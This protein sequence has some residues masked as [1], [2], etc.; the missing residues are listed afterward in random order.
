VEVAQRGSRSPPHR[1]GAPEVRLALRLFLEPREEGQGQVYAVRRRPAGTAGLCDHRP[2]GEQ[3]GLPPPG[4]PIPG[5][6]TGPARAQHHHRRGGRGAPRHIRLRQRLLHEDR[7]AHRGE[8]VLRGPGRPHN[9]HDDPQ[10]GRADQRLS[11]E[12][13]PRR[14]G[15]GV[16]LELRLH[17]ACQEGPDGTLR[18]TGRQERGWTFQQHRR[19]HARIFHGPRLCRTTDCR[20]IERRA[21]HAGDHDGRDDHLEGDDRG[22][23]S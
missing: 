17:A 5:Q 10:L 21:H 7:V 23:V 8:R 19:L 2:Q 1:R 12:R 15:R 18:G 16:H 11:P 20:G 22:G 6:D 3:D 13:H 4:M 9:L 14:G